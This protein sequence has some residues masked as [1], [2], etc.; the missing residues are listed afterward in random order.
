MNDTESKKKEMLDLFVFVHCG[1]IYVHF[2]FSN[3]IKLTLL[4]HTL[5]FSL[6]KMNIKS[7]I[8]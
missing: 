2:V 3:F 4:F 8:P 5:T 6:P 1:K 7:C